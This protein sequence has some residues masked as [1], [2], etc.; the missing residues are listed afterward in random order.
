MTIMGVPFI[1]DDNIGMFFENR[2]DLLMGRDCF[3]LDYPP[4]GLV[5]NLL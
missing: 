5:V 2:D 4:I 3:V 1:F